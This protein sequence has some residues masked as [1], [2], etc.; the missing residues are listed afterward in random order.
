MELCVKK[1]FIDKNDKSKTYNVGDTLQTDELDRINDLVGRGLCV[2]VSVGGSL[3]E[4][5]SE[6]VAFQ[7][8]EYDLNVVKAALESINSPV[9][10]NAGVKGVT[11]AIDALSEESITALKEALEK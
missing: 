5:A 4:K 6:K 11:K 1:P 2:I 8:E 7:G 9:A 10:K 3:P